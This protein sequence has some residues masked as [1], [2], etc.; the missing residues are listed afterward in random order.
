MKEQEEVQAVFGSE[1]HRIQASDVLL[2]TLSSKAVQPL[3]V[4][5]PKEEEALDTVAPVAQVE[6]SK[7]AM[8][9]FCHTSQ[10]N[11]RC[12]M[13]IGIGVLSTCCFVCDGDWK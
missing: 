13:H 1:N 4:P 9:A 8:T 7:N 11:E 6:L 12:M 10:R 5:V 3:H 2:V